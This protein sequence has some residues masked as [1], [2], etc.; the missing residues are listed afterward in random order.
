MIIYNYNF[1]I[2]AYTRP[3][4][5]TKLNLLM[6]SVHFGRTTNRKRVCG[7]L[8][9]TSPNH[10]GSEPNRTGTGQ[11]HAFK[12]MTL[13]CY[14]FF[15]WCC[16]QKLLKIC[17]VWNFDWIL[18]WNSI[19]FSSDFWVSEYCYSWLQSVIVQTSSACRDL[20]LIQQLNKQQI[21][22]IRSLSALL[23]YN[24]TQCSRMTFFATP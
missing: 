17:L 11:N 16:V 5:W 12:L 1:F 13:Q 15:G 24:Q 9:R 19:R 6:S 14:K 21:L 4:Y 18:K 3:P 20:L 8:N 22:G 10:Y 23:P 7:S 2:F